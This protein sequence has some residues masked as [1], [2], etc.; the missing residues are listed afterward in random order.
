MKSLDSVYPNVAT[1]G[2]S[3]RCELA[4]PANKGVGKPDAP[5]LQENKLPDSG[6]LRISSSLSKWRAVVMYRVS[7]SFPANVQ[8]VMLGTG[9]EITCNISP[10]GE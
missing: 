8:E 7:K 10:S 5:G 6:Y 9:I 3:N 1:L 4:Y 2:Y